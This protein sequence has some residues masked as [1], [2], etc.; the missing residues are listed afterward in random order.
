V[1]TRDRGEPLGIVELLLGDLQRRLKEY[2]RCSR[3]A[4]PHDVLIATEASTPRTAHGRSVAR[5]SAWSRTPCEALLRGQ[6]QAGHL[7]PRGRGSGSG[8]LLFSDGGEVVVTSTAEERAMSRATGNWR[9]SARA[10]GAGA[11]RIGRQRK[12][13]D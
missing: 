7:D 12:F 13:A 6:V 2:D 9:W 11:H 4:T 5:S 8:T 10:G 3:S 1:S